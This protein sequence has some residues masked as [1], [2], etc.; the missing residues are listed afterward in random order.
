[1]LY[2]ASDAGSFCTGAMYF[3]DGG[4]QYS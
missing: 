4:M 3:I 1:M 2:L